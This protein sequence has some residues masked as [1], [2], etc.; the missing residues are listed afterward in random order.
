LT[1]S[2]DRP[3]QTSRVLT[4][5]QA[6]GVVETALL[7]CPEIKVVGVA[8][9]GDPLASDEALETLFLVRQKYPELIGCLSTNG[10]ALVNSMEKIMAANVQTITVTVN[11][12]EAEILETLNRG[13]LMNGS[14]I[15]GRQGALLLIEAQEKGI[16]QAHENQLVIKVNTV[17]VPGINDGHISQV[18]EK[19]RS[20]GADI[21]NVIPLIPANELA[22]VSMPTEAEKNLAVLAAEKY[23][24]VK[25][26]CRRCRADACGV[27]GLSEFS[28]E[29]YKDLGEVETFSHG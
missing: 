16:R 8:G 15:G 27:P 3:G 22:H 2:I 19:V 1:E 4:P 5:D 9:P 21:L 6:L 28:Q 25:H 26:N 7:L 11:A 24:P 14:F 12:V 29:L 23:L 18:A 13:V 10:L 17:L 20:W